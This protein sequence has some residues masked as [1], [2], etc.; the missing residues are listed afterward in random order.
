MAYLLGWN[1]YFSVL[2]TL[3]GIR[4]V[5]TFQNEQIKDVS[6]AIE[7]Y[8]L[9]AVFVVKAIRAGI[10]IYKA[11]K[12]NRGVPIVK[13]EQEEKGPPEIGVSLCRICYS[14]L[15][16]RSLTKCGHVFCWDCIIR[17]L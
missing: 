16:N 11:K 6:Y 15:T 5:Y 10:K 13:V 4:Y 14:P 3:L 8:L 1:K 17:A 7:G 9:L 12:M 2:E